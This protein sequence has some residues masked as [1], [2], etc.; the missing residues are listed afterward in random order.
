MFPSC[1][2]PNQGIHLR[3][4]RLPLPGIPPTGIL[5][6]QSVLQTSE[7]TG[8]GCTTGVGGWLLHLIFFLRSMRMTGIPGTHMDDPT[9]QRQWIPLVGDCTCR[10]RREARV[11]NPKYR[12]P[13]I[14][15]CSR[16]PEISSNRVWRCLLILRLVEKVGKSY[17]L[18]INFAALVVYWSLN[19]LDNIGW[20]KSRGSPQIAANVPSLLEAEGSGAAAILKCPVSSSLSSISF[21][22]EQPGTFVGTSLTRTSTS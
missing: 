1:R 12:M 22:S 13:I 15:F 20:A 9:I 16:T 3:L 21:D 4:C 10:D 19:S 17:A 2:L 7:A 11:S 8:D 14:Y 5:S 18:H 6:Q